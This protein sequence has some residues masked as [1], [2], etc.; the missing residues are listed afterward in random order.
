MKCVLTITGKYM[1]DTQYHMF[2][3]EEEM[4]KWCKKNNVGEPV[5]RFSARWNP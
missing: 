3:S 1:E 5:K 4:I 2:D